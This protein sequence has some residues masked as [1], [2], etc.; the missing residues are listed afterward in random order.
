[1][2]ESQTH[3]SIQKV[4]HLYQLAAGNSWLGLRC[5]TAQEVQR[6][7]QIVAVS[8]MSILQYWFIPPS[9]CKSDRG[10]TILPF[11]VYHGWVVR[12]SQV[13]P[14]S[15]KSERT[16]LT[17]I[18]LSKQAHNHRYI[19][20]FVPSKNL[21]VAALLIDPLWAA[22][23]KTCL[24]QSECL[25]LTRLATIRAILVVVAVDYEYLYAGGFGSKR[26]FGGRAHLVSIKGHRPV[27][28]I[29]RKDK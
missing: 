14:D 6:V 12:E 3:L 19:M 21:I 13:T 18:Q 28:G 16:L 25:P 23:I 5:A 20:K 2:P 9:P 26:H 8:K 1:M 17:R 7:E 15:M 22:P 24:D 27:M 4:C 29:Y 11:I 10:P